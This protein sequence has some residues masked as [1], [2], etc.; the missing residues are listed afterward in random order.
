MV[1]VTYQLV[2]SCRSSCLKFSKVIGVGLIKMKNTARCELSCLF[3]RRRFVDM[4]ALIFQ[5]C[6]YI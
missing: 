1:D 4:F 5:G 2:E 6:T 3:L